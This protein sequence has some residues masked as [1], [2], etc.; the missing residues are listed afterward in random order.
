MRARDAVESLFAELRANPNVT[1]H[2]AVA[3]K[4]ADPK[5]VLAIAAEVKGRHGVEIPPSLLDLYAEM[6]GFTLVWEPRPTVR[7]D[8]RPW[9]LP[10]CFNQLQ[11]IASLRFGDRADELRWADSGAREATAALQFFVDHDQEDQGSFLV[12][13]DG[14]THLYYVHDQGEAVERLALDF[15]AY[16]ARFLASRGFFCW[17]SLAGDLDAARLGS[18][19]PL[20]GAAREYAQ[21]ME[22]LSLAP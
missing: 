13:I 4:G 12:A 20:R 3:N 15:D 7:V 2:Q 14:E 10:P 5:Q 9:S 17:Q 18:P 16:F 22:A 1:V 8:G 19:G 6:D 21:W 11:P